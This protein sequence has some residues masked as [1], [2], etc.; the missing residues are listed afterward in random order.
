MEKDCDVKCWMQSYNIRLA[1]RGGKS[2]TQ[3]GSKLE[4]SSPNDHP[5]KGLTP[6]VSPVAQF[7]VV[8]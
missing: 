7:R 3:L 8:L 6:R 5:Q 4:D 2:F 1:A